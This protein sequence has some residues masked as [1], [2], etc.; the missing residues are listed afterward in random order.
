M[1]A[2]NKD[3]ILMVTDIN[4]EEKYVNL[5]QSVKSM[6]IL[7]KIFLYLNERQKLNLI[8]YSKEYLDLLNINIEHYK[9]LSGKIKIPQMNGYFKVY[10]LKTNYLLFEGQYL[11]DKKSGKCKEYNIKGNLIFEGEYLNGY[12]NGKCKEYDDYGKLIF[13]GEYLNGNKNGKCKEY[14][15]YGKIKFE[16]E[17][18][19]GKIWNGIIYNNENIYKFEIK[20]GNGEYKEYNYKNKLLF[21]GKYIKGIKYGKEYDNNGYLIFE[22]EYLNNLKWNGKIKEYHSF[23]NEEGYICYGYAKLFDFEKEPEIKMDEI[24]NNKIKFE[25]EYLYGLRNGKGREFNFDG[26]LMYEDYFINNKRISGEREAN[27]KTNSKYYIKFEGE[28]L[29]GGKYKRGREYDFKG[30]IL[31]E[32]EYLYDKKNGKAEEYNYNGELIFKGEYLNGVRWIGKGKEKLY[33]R[34]R[35]DFEGEY[36]NGIKKGKAYNSDGKL[37]FDGEVLNNQKW[38]GKGNEY[39]KNGKIKYE[40]EFLMGKKWNGIIYDIDGNSILE[41]KNGRGKGREYNDDG[42]LIFEGEYINGEKKKWKR[43]RILS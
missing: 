4:I 6:F 39:Y 31:F 12:K 14:Y 32:G 17:Y 1:E 43:K 11:K 41:F 38:N 10:D 20:D 19:N 8:K 3:K 5:K 36:I 9:N 23:P 13:E 33:M 34:N 29:N 16:G 40:G 7:K 26:E 21:E 37:E 35:L 15:D 27:E 24:N 2:N 22:G 30:N 28:F 42:K 18:L 25:G